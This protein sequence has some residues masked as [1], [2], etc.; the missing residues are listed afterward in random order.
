MGSGAI[1]VLAITGGKGG[2]G[3]TS[4]AINLAVAVAKSGRRVALLDADFG[5]A[6]VDVMLGLRA[7]RTIEQVLDG[8]CSLRDIMLSG[9]AGVRIIPSASGARRLTRLNEFEQAGLIRAF[10]ELSQQIDVLIVDTAAGIADAVLRVVSASQEILLVLCDEP[11]S[12]TDAYAMIKVLNQD[13]QKVRFRVLVNKADSE[14]EARLVFEKLRGVCE[15]FLE[16]SLLFVGYI[17]SDPALLQSVKKQ[18]AVV[19]AS[20]GSASSRAFFRLAEQLSGWRSRERPQ[21]ALAFFVDQLLSSETTELV[22][23]PAVKS[24]S[25]EGADAN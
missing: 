24:S 11:S 22:A 1:Q 3:K 23:P 2:V 9:P 5:L 6:N 15:R 21:A 13:F 14:P 18:R 12:I 17:P 4:V 10:D 19:D 8:D 20:P 16:V 7:E 25:E